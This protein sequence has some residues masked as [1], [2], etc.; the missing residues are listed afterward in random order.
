MPDFP[1]ALSTLLLFVEFLTLSYSTPKAV[2]NVLSSLRFHHQRLGY[3]VQQFEHLQFKLALRSL[4]FTLRATPSPALPFPPSLLTPLVEAARVLGTWALAFRALCVFAFFTFA[5]LG[6]LVPVSVGLFDGSRYPSL[7]DLSVGQGRAD[8]RI[9]FSKTRQAADGGFWAPLLPAAELPC[10]VG[11]ARCLRERASRE[12]FPSASPLFA[13]PG[14]GGGSPV[15]LTQ[16]QARVFLK[17]CLMAL[18][19]P[20][21][22]Y[23]FHSFR[24][25][26]CSFAFDKGA[27]E[28]DLAL[29]GD[30][31]SSAVRAYY[32]AEGAR[33]R[34]AGLLSGN[35]VLANP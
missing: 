29:H 15:S 25:G 3:P 6:S 18:Q 22:Q 8:L 35:P 16:T 26:G 11:L 27:A 12:S 13:A 7:A 4:P 30:W 24:R 19:L 21:D 20:P 1:A 2:S 14:S 10:P 31:R 17:R 34:V 5:R 33:L 9:K 32:P 28:S 23:S